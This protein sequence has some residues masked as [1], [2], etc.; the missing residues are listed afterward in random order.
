MAKASSLHAAHADLA[1]LF[2]AAGDLQGAH[3][4][5][6]SLLYAS[7]GGRFAPEQL[8]A[9]THA[10]TDRAAEQSSLPEAIAPQL[11]WG[12][13][14][15]VPIAKPHCL[16]LQGDAAAASLQ[17]I[18]L[19]FISTSRSAGALHSL[20]D[21]L[22]WLLA[23]QTGQPQLPC[24]LAG[25][26]AVC[27]TATVDSV[28]TALVQHAGLA[29]AAKVS[30]AADTLAESLCGKAAQLVSASAATG[31]ALTTGP[32]MQTPGTPGQTASSTSNTS[33]AHHETAKAALTALHSDLKA[34]WRLWCLL[35]LEAH[36]CPK[37]PQLR[38]WQ[39]EAQQYRDAPLCGMLQSCNFSD[40]P[41]GTC[42]PLLAAGAEVRGLQASKLACCCLRSKVK[43]HAIIPW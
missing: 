37:W 43:D 28:A 18:I 34:A 26:R 19:R 12:T 27:A 1:T 7:S 35:A 24:N 4:Q 41:Q 10:D 32:A 16:P 2:V 8:L 36:G 33:A 14:P 29:P 11:Q 31:R 42:E 38:G 13:A 6:C 25:L 39:R 40:T 22:E 9:A 23:R 17:G 3:E 5:C 21:A 20:I 15:D 30:A